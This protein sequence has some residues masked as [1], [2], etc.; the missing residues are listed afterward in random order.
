[1]FWISAPD[2]RGNIT[3]IISIKQNSSFPHKCKSDLV[4][5]LEAS[6]MQEDI[7][8]KLP[9]VSRDDVGPRVLQKS[10]SISNSRSSVDRIALQTFKYPR[11]EDRNNETA[12]TV[13]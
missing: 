12:S 13:E 10:I 5:I 3:V 7:V 4:F 2:I 8:R 11:A 6:N 9:Q 1:M